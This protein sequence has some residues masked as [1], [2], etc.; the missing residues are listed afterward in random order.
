MTVL[1]GTAD[2][3]LPVMLMLTV[4]LTDPLEL[5]TSSSV[6]VRKAILVMVFNV[7]TRKEL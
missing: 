2:I 5:S 6:S 1:W 3:F 4:G 7:W